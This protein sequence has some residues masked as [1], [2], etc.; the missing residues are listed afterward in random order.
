M[1]INQTLARTGQV[2]ARIP[3]W[4]EL[5]GP[6]TGTVTLPNRLCWSG[7]P[8]FDVGDPRERLNLYTTLLGEG[9]REDIARWV[10]PEHLLADWPRIRRLTARDLIG[11]WEAHLP[12]L[13]TT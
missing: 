6:A 13:A 8:R 5:T 4:D 3:D 1:S 7:S 2:A 10:H 11:V 9:R 12:V